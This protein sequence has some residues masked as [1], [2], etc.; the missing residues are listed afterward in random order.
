MRNKI[1][2]YELQ[3]HSPSG[4]HA[5]GSPGP[6]PNTTVE[7]TQYPTE[8]LRQYDHTVRSI[9]CRSA[10]CTLT[11]KTPPSVHGLAV[12]HVS[13]EEFRPRVQC[14]AAG[15]VVS[16]AALSA[17][18][19]RIRCGHKREYC[20]GHRPKRSHGHRCL[21]VWMTSSNSPALSCSEL[22]YAC[23]DDCVRV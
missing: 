12:R 19:V 21:G 1:Q 17:A 20:H 11:L 3:N 16:T 7:T 15:S 8:T 23:Y 14:H 10:V 13:V 6:V 4:T 5:H 22:R 2:F 9:I 18:D